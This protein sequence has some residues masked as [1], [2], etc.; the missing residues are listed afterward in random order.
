VTRLYRWWMRRRGFTFYDSYDG[1]EF[2]HPD[3]RIR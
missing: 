3:G 2:R 1:G